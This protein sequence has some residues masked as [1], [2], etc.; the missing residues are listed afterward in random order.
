MDHAS[1]AAMLAAVGREIEMRVL[2]KAVRFQAERRVIAIGNK[3]VV[4]H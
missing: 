1:S 2:A 4:F 3:T